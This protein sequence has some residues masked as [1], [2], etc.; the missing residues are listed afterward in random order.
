MPWSD[1]A[2]GLLQKSKERVYS[3]PEVGGGC[4]RGLEPVPYVGR[5]PN[6]SAHS[7]QS[8]KDESGSEARV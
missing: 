6:R 1:V 2:L 4:C 7:E 3:R 5:I 8:V